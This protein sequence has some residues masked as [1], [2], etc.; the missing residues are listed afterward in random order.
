M[1]QASKGKTGGTMLELWKPPAGAGDPIGALTSTYTFAPGL[2]DE[3]C[4]ARFLEIESE[5]DRENLSFL[6]ER[7]ARLGAV[8]AGVLVDY[9]MAGVEHSLR[10]DVLPVRIPG[11]KQ[12]AKLTVLRWSRCIRVIIASANLTEQGYRTNFEVAA[13]A[14]LTTNGTDAQ[15]ILDSL[16]FLQSLVSFVPGADRLPAQVKRARGFLSDALACA[17]SWATAP[18]RE[19]IR[20]RLACTIPVNSSTKDRSALEELLT[21]CRSRGN[22]PQTARVASPF[23][24]V[25]DDVDHATRELCK[26]MANGRS[27][28]LTFAVPSDRGAFKPE[29]TPRLCAP[30]SV[31]RTARKYAT[32]VAIEVLP[33]F[34]DKNVRPWHAKL[35]ALADESYFALMAGSS[36]FTCAGLGLSQ[37]RNAEANLVTIADRLAYSREAG[38]VSA[39]WP[40]VQALP[41][42]DAAEWAGPNKTLIEEEQSA[43][44][45]PPPGFLFITFEAG[46]NARLLIH[47]DPGHLP[48][49]WSLHSVQGQIVTQLLGAD[50]WEQAGKTPIAVVRWKSPTGPEKLVVRWSNFEAFLPINIEDSRL[51]P[52]PTRLERMTADDMLGILAAADPSAAIRAWSR[53]QSQS[54]DFDEELDSATPIELDPLRRYELGSTFL[55]R[56]RRRARVLL[57]LRENLQ[58][59]VWGH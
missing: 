46:E 49:E 2:F 54:S 55:H 36:N 18:K 30:F 47:L 27:R 50:E 44:V 10:W 51:L 6:L 26:R 25:S 33:S 5:P 53:T 39:I 29:E 37:H 3:Q 13:S 9:T 38:M 7:E 4:L 8:Y 11:G 22:S 19:I 56:I 15:L 57:Q 48:T 31:V 14:D 52:P 42:P 16:E 24:D 41:D 32:T 20:R 58:R 1:S 12:H 35:M 59:P 28:H 43:N 40:T 34:E 17:R 21:I 45:A 23:F